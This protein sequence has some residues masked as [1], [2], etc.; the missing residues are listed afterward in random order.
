MASAKPE[1][2]KMAVQTKNVEYSKEIDDVAFLLVKIVAD[3]RQGKGIAEV[4]S[5]AVAPLVDALAGVDQMG[6]E[7]SANRKVALQT[8]GYRTGELT[9]AILGKS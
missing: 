6:A 7:V 1:K 2:S 5:G 8:I 3:I 4:V 9:D